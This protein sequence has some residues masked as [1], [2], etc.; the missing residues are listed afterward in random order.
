MTTIDCGSYEAAINTLCDLFSITKEQ[1]ETFFENFGGSIETEHNLYTE[2]CN[3]LGTPSAISSIT[4][5]H[6]SRLPARLKGDASP[7]TDRGILPLNEVSDEILDFAYTLCKDKITLPRWQDFKNILMTDMTISYRLQN[8]TGPFACL[9]SDHLLSGDHPHG[10]YADEGSDFID[11]LSRIIQ[12]DLEI[13]DFY[14]TYC[15][16]TIPVIIKFT[17]S[18]NLERYGA[19]KDTVSY[20]WRSFLKIDHSTLYATYS[21]EGNAVPATDI[22]EVIFLP[23]AKPCGVIQ[24]FSNR[25]APVS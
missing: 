1:I 20:A 16:N 18:K 3:N 6:G 14:T 25:S 4:F 7:F 21:G 15:D 9:V 23:A 2:F 19:I 12:K 5:Y 24:A 22:L 13:E 17:V 11:D 10:A 8:D